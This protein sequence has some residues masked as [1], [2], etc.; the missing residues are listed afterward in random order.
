VLGA[1]LDPLIPNW[2]RRAD[3][4]YRN[5]PAGDGGGHI[6]PIERILECAFQ[7]GADRVCPDR[8][9]EPRTADRGTAS[10]FVLVWMAAVRG[11]Y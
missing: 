5:I 2:I 9:E 10:N 6:F 8:G 1:T 4:S 7:S 3:T 11:G